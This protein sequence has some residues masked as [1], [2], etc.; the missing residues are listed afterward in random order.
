MC[1]KYFCIEF[2]VVDLSCTIVHSVVMLDNY[3]GCHVVFLYY[4]SFLER[5]AGWNHGQN[6]RVWKGTMAAVRLLRA[7]AE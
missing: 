5:A 6:A 4:K 3:N 2:F 1:Y 7:A